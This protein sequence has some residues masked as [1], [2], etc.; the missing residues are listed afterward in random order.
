MP[1]FNTPQLINATIEL[2]AADIRIIASDRTDTNVEIHAKKGFD[3]EPDSIVHRIKVEY[4]NG[5][6]LIKGPREHGFF[7]NGRSDAVDVEISMPTGSHVRGNIAMGG[8]HAE[9]TLGEC[10]LKIADGSIDL[11]RTGAVDLNISNGDI[12]VEN[13]RGDAQI[14]VASGAVRIGEISGTAAIRVANGATDVGTVAGD[15][16]LSTANGSVTI[17]QAASSVVARTANGNIRVGEVR[18]GSVVVETQHGEL[19]VGIREGTA[20][21]L[22]AISAHGN[23]H[24]HLDAHDSR[25]QSTETAEVHARTAFGDIVIRRAD[26]HTPAR[27]SVALAG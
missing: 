16:Q 21:W 27:Q 26:L 24:N 3:G 5:R 9:G 15:L 7:G 13:A 14:A 19:E 22:D 20:V 11:G 25:P 18:R 6:L 1:T 10:Q 23:V 17:G 12:T 4:A 2:A 8:F